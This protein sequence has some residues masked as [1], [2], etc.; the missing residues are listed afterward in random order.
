LEEVVAVERAARV[1]ASRFC[2]AIIPNRQIANSRPPVIA[3][4][5]IRESF[6]QCASRAIKR[7]SK[8]LNRAWRR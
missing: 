2:A 3:G 6:R 4:N 7:S 1:L 5:L 8:A